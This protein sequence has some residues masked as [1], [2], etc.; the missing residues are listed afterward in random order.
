MIRKITTWKPTGNRPKRF[1][2]SIRTIG[3]PGWRKKEKNRKPWRRITEGVKRNE[4]L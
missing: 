3:I 1:V 4:K 2:E